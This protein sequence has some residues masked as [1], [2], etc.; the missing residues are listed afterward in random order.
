M[1]RLGILQPIAVR[2]L[3]AE[4]IYQIIF[5]ERRYEAARTAGRH[6]VPC[7]VKTP[8][9]EDVLLHQVVENWQRAELHP[10]ELADA[11]AVL[12]DANGYSQKQLADL[13]G[14]PGSEISRLLSLLKLNPAVQQA[15]RREETGALSRRHLI[16][17]A[18]L[19]APDQEGALEAVQV[20]NL[21]ALDTERFVQEAKSRRLGEKRRGAPAGEKLRY[22]TSK[23]TVTLAFRR[24]EVTAE[25]IHAALDEVREQVDCAEE[26]DERGHAHEGASCDMTL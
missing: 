23:A 10:Y 25:D 8:K 3:E 22:R 15:A 18:Q 21:T 26:T 2:Y 6:E 7:W 12:R 1:R 24:K 14:K 16:A 19:P 17:L 9:A 4:D 20:K 11:L 13:T 5:G